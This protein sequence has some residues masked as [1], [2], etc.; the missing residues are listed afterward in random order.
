MSMAIP[1]QSAARARNSTRIRNQNDSMTGERKDV[2]PSSAIVPVDASARTLHGQDSSHMQRLEHNNSDGVLSQRLGKLLL[3]GEPFP[4]SHRH[5][6]APRHLDGGMDIPIWQSPEAYAGSD[7]SRWRKRKS[8][9]GNGYP[10]GC[11][12]ADPRPSR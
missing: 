3:G 2:T 9:H 1:C 6:H 12:W 8:S 7:T 11:R 5:I 10:A 4:G